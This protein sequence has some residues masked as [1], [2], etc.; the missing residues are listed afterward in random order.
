MRDFRKAVRIA[1][2][3]LARGPL[4]TRAVRRACGLA[5]PRLR[6]RFIHATLEAENADRA[7]ARVWKA[8][9]FSWWMTMLLHHFPDMTP[10][11]TKMLKA[12]RDYLF[13]SHAAMTALAENYVGL[14][15]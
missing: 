11:E 10:F 3:V 8:E 13:S 5:A 4:S 9:R 2:I 12:E 1:G 14:P 6:P 15:Y 7:L